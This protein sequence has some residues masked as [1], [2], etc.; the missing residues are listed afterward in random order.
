M[1]RQASDTAASSVQSVQSERRQRRAVLDPWTPTDQT[2]PDQTTGHTDHQATR[3]AQRQY[4]SAWERSAAAGGSG[5]TWHTLSTSLTVTIIIIISSSSS[6]SKMLAYDIAHMVLTFVTCYAFVHH[7]LRRPTMFYRRIFWPPCRLISQMAEV[8]Q[9]FSRI[10]L[11]RKNEPDKSAKL[12]ST[13]DPP[14]SQ[15]R[16]FGMS[17]EHGSPKGGMATNNG[18]IW[19]AA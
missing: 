2:R 12:T 6:S 11:A 4:S 5:G 7:L 1:R 13:F 8:Y 3:L 18:S 17:R 16:I 9:W 15:T 14:P 10:G 19:G